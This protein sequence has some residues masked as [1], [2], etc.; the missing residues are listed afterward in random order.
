MP[1][2]TSDNKID[3]IFGEKDLVL[4]LSVKPYTHKKNEVHEFVPCKTV[5]CY[6][7]LNGAQTG[8]APQFE[9]GPAEINLSFTDNQAIDRMIDLLTELRDSSISASDTDEE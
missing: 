1:L 3:L 7:N 4:N 8:D 9:K 6:E 5:Q 2:L